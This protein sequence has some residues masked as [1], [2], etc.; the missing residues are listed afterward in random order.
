MHLVT[1]LTAEEF[2]DDEGVADYR[3]SFQVHP[4]KRVNAKT[5]VGGLSVSVDGD[6]LI[7]A[8]AEWMQGERESEH[9]DVVLPEKGDVE[10]P[11]E[12]VD[13]VTHLS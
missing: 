7:T 1:H 2:V 6:Y 10:N 5:R 11:E 9:N 12:I 3:R 8:I 4:T 13:A